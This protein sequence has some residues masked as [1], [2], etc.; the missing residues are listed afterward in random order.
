MFV[1]VCKKTIVSLSSIYKYVN[2]RP[3][4]DIVVL[5][6]YFIK[7]MYII[8]VTLHINRFKA[9][10]VIRERYVIIVMKIKFYI[11]VR[12]LRQDN[13][14]SVLGTGNRMFFF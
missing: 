2:L 11:D 12:L 1:S 13:C 3:P 6:C 9:A 4:T 8:V 14:G 5:Q 7:Y 10:I